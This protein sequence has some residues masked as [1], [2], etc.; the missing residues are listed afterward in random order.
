MKLAFSFLVSALLLPFSEASVPLPDRWTIGTVEASSPG[1]FQYQGMSQAWLGTNP[2]EHVRATFYDGDC[3]D[4]TTNGADAQ[5]YDDTPFYA[6]AGFMATDLVQDVT[7]EDG[8]FAFTN[9]NLSWDHANLQLDFAT[10]PR[11]MTAM[12]DFGSDGVL[13]YCVRLGLHDGGTSIDEINFQESIVT[14][15]ITMDGTFTI[16]DIGVEPKTQGT[17]DAAQSYSVVASLCTAQAAET[18]FNQGEAI[19]VCITLDDT[20]KTGQVEITSVDAFTWKRADTEDQGAIGEPSTS[21]FDIYGL[22]TNGLTM[23]EPI[24]AGT[25]SVT[26]TS[27]LF[28]KFYE[29]AGTVTAHGSVTMAFANSCEAVTAAYNR[30]V[31]ACNAAKTAKNN[32]KVV[33]ET[34]KNTWRV[35]CHAEDMASSA[36]KQACKGRRLGGTNNNDNRRRHLQEGATTESAFDVSVDLNKA[37]DGPVALQQTAAAGAGTSITVVATIVGLVS[38]ILLA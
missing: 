32:A 19:A 2:N 30:A 36:K 1:S 21:G 8:E 26:I 24:V 10:N 11:V 25:T 37:D 5:G 20:A 18:R 28:A 14:L 17:S 31:V 23:M 3:K 4:S 6:V 33:T 27:V 29:S 35:D 7:Q 15:T 9:T 38:A 34:I 13:V 12:G 22:A 16:T